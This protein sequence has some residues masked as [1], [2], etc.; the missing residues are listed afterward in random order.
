MT[1]KNVAATEVAVHVG[2]RDRC[3][4]V[5]PGLLDPRGSWVRH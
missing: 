3:R 5:W 4:S 1:D 2:V